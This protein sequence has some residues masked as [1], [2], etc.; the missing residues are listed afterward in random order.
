MNKIAEDRMENIHKVSSF[1]INYLFHTKTDKI[2]K[3]RSCFEIRE[4]KW[5][6]IHT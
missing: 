5:N 4:V 3:L 1:R 2:Y 6:E